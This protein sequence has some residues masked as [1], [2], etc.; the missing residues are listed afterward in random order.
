[1]T[2]GNDG[3][4]ENDDPFAY[5][6]RSEGGEQQEPEALQPGTPRTSHHQVTRVGERRPPQQPATGG[7]GYPPQ[8][9]PGQ[10]GYGG[11]QQSRRLPQHR[12]LPG[13]RLWEE[14]TDRRRY[15]SSDR[16]PTWTKVRR[17][18]SG[19]LAL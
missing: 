6:Y 15:G 16:A 12:V 1:M 7:Y 5:L 18:F 9:Q 13:F 11:Q 4:P 14:Y 8:N 3:T 19:S 17:H 2:A 10:G